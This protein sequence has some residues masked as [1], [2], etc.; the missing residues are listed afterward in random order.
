MEGQK[1]TIKEEISKHD[2]AKLAKTHANTNMQKYSYRIAHSLEHKL[3]TAPFLSV[4]LFHA[5]Q[6]HET[7]SSSSSKH[8]FESSLSFKCSHTC[9][10][11]FNS[12]EVGGSGNKVR[13]SNFF[14]FFSCMPSG[15]I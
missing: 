8:R 13:F 10:I 12:G 11:G 7:I 5:E 6:Q 1:R 15:A 9:S 2:F 14:K 3:L 4:K